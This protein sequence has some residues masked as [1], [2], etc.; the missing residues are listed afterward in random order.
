M[1]LKGRK[2]DTEKRE[3]QEQYPQAGKGK[4]N[5]QVNEFTWLGLR[6]EM[7]QRLQV[8]HH[9]FKP[10]NPHKDRSTELILSS[11]LLTSTCTPTR[12][13]IAGRDTVEGGG[14]V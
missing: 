3:F 5:G 12:H 9:E 10:W 8:G 11:C 1:S 14:K 7:A 13:R 6:V 4:S 2:Y